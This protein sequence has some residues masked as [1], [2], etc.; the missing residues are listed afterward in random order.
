MSVKRIVIG[1][2]GAAG[3]FGAIHAKIE[4]PDAEVIILEKSIETLAKVAISGG[5]RCNLTHACFDPD[6]LVGHYPR[7]HRELRGAFHRWNPRHTVDWFEQRGVR[8]KTEADG[9]M[10]PVTDSSQ[11]IVDCLR[12]EARRLGVRVETRRGVSGA[13]WNQAD[14]CFDLTLHGASPRSADFLL[15]ATGGNRQSGGLAVAQGFG[16]QIVDPVPSLFGVHVRD[17]LLKGLAGIVVPD[18]RVGIADSRLAQGGGLLITHWGLSGP[19][20]LKLSAWGA[21][22]LAAR[23]YRLML[24]VNWWGQDT[25][26]AVEAVLASWRRDHGARSVSTANP[27]PGIPRRLWE[28]LVQRANIGGDTAWSRLPRAGLEALL[29]ACVDCRLAVSGKSMNKEEFVTC[30]GI[31][32]NEVDMK[33]MQSRI[34]PGLYFAGE[35]L[36]VDGVTGGFNF[37]A[38][39]TTGYLAGTA[40]ARDILPPLR[41]ECS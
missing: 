35:I 14:R 27:S 40:M 18:V 34:R 23:D 15:L 41:G 22:E 13:T 12:E 9:R 32:L 4:D 25:R 10:F 17:P 3:F 20:I 38:A 6:R 24:A 36:D 39:W 5:G 33:T 21:R 28:R 8:I 16:H 19:A 7:G 37:Q 1:G 26:H 11:T 31:A 30:G 2:G 29:D